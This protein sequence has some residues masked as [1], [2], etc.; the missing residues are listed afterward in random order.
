MKLVSALIMSAIVLST[1]RAQAQPRPPA[2]GSFVV[3]IKGKLANNRRFAKLAMYSFQDDG[4]MREDFWY[5][6]DD[7][8]NDYSASCG[9]NQAIGL[10]DR[11]VGCAGSCGSDSAQY[12]ISPCKF[13]TGSYTTLYGTWAI[14][15]GNSN[16]ID[17]TWSWGDTEQW[18]VTWKDGTYETYK[19]EL[20]AASYLNGSVYLSTA[21]ARTPAAPNAGW[22]FGGPSYGFTVGVDSVSSN[23]KT[24]QGLYVQYNAWT[25]ADTSVAADTMGLTTFS[26]TNT[27]ALRLIT[28]GCSGGEETIYRY[29]GRPTT[30]S[31]PLARRVM[32]HHGHDFN[33]NGHITDNPGHVEPGLQIID[34]AQNVRGFV[35]VETSPNWNTTGSG[36]SSGSAA[37]QNTVGALFYVER[38]WVEDSGT[39]TDFLCGVDPDNAE[40]PSSCP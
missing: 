36:G 17:I 21:L 28:A 29:W 39:W 22:A 6:E 35:F 26:T 12:I 3:T 4:T 31:G 37:N 10:S 13:L 19:M 33:C 5:W 14:N 40:T 2:P 23:K 24:Y 27:N 9:S 38:A 30:N 20:V 32:Y 15:S 34:N 8:R 1:A 25:A 7:D 18:R 16:R 11:Q